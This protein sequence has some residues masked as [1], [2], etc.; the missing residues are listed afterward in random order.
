M[1][2]IRL[3]REV[4]NVSRAGT[5]ATYQGQDKGGLDLRDR[6]H[7]LCSAG[8]TL[9]CKTPSCRA[10]CIIESANPGQNVQVIPD[11]IS[12]EFDFECGR[13]RK[14]HHYTRDDVELN[15][16]PSSIQ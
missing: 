1:H 14:T 4:D 6:Y 7:P 9:L 12:Q 3:P 11:S 2:K 8:W 10:L 5:H 13:C 15:S 16:L